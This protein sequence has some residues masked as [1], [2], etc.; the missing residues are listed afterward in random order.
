M[1]GGEGDR[2]LDPFDT[3]PA[4]YLTGAVSELRGGWRLSIKHPGYLPRRPSCPKKGYL[5]G[6]TVI[7]DRGG[8]GS[9]CCPSIM[10]VIS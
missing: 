7:G 4:G 5:G 1:G 10:E 9:R 2:R 3:S 6:V 8:W